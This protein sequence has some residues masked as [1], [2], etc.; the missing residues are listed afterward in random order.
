MLVKTKPSDFKCEGTNIHYDNKL[1]ILYFR[2]IS[3]MEHTGNRKQP[4]KPLIRL[5]IDYS[6]GFEMFN[7][8]R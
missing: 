7:S 4:E 6:G 2:S 8:N 5:R 3:E 1:N